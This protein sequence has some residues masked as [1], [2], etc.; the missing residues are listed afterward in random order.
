[1]SMCTFLFCDNL[2]TEFIAWAP[3]VPILAFR[4]ESSYLCRCHGAEL[5]GMTGDG[6]PIS[7]ARTAALLPLPP[8][9]LAQSQPWL[10][11]QGPM[12]SW[13]A[14]SLYCCLV[15]TFLLVN[16]LHCHVRLHI[17]KNPIFSNKITNNFKKATVE[18]TL[19]MGLF[20][21]WV[22]LWGNRSYTR[23]ASASWTRECGQRMEHRLLTTCSLGWFLADSSSKSRKIENSRKFSFILTWTSTQPFKK[24]FL[25]M[26]INHI[27]QNLS[28]VH[29]MDKGIP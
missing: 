6:P 25:Q 3:A 5:W 2:L 13:T 12:T 23:E 24:Y 7:G 20:W 4:T 11:P 14:L 9:T 27:Y 26:F 16:I 15:Y 17:K 22:P 29:L 8:P 21:D 19:S 28:L 10:P 1:M 18:H